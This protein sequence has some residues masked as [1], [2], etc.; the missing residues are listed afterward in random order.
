MESGRESKGGE[1]HVSGD[2]AQCKLLRDVAASLSKRGG[3]SVLSDGQQTLPKRVLPCVE[4][5][6][7]RDSD[8]VLPCVE[9]ADLFNA[10]NKGPLSV[11]VD[12]GITDQTYNSGWYYASFSNSKVTITSGTFENSKESL[13]IARRIVAAVFGVSITF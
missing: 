5:A 4:P 13:G 1:D 12:T 3:R 7:F 11:N 6:G 9:Q 8:G 10:G 2:T